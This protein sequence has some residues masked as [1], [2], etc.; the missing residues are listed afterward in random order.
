MTPPKRQMAAKRAFD[1]ALSGAALLLLSPLFLGLALFIKLRSPGPVFFRQTRVGLNGKEFSLLKF[2]S[3]H[4]NT[5]PQPNA[6]TTRRADSRVFR[7]GETIRKYKLDEL[8]QILNVLLGDMS[9]IGP[10]PTVREDY[11]RMS[12]EQRRRVSIRPGLSGL[13]QISGNTSLSWP[14]RIVLDLEYINTLSIWT[15]AR[16][17]LRTAKLILSGRADTHPASDDEWS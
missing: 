4:S 3:M 6:S 1:I 14:E 12:L 9:L 17:I 16:I 11:D 15:D 7:G 10:R 2:R 8:P 13:A 5:A